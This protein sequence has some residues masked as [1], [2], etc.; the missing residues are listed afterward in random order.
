[1]LNVSIGKYLPSFEGEFCA[2]LQGQAIQE[3][4]FLLRTV[5]SAVTDAV[6]LV[7]YKSQL[8]FISFNY[9]DRGFV[10]ACHSHPNLIWTR[11]EMPVMYAVFPVCCY[12]LGYELGIFTR[13]VGIS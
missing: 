4:F 1:M 9:L 12:D 5:F 13:S 10:T 6:L 8:L 11:Y 3:E 7:N 2:H